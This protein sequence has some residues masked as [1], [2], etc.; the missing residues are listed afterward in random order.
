MPKSRKR[1]KHHQNHHHNRPLHLVRKAAATAAAATPGAALS[2]AANAGTAAATAPPVE[3]EAA[4]A[5]VAAAAVTS[6]AVRNDVHQPNRYTAASASA[7]APPSPS[8]AHS[9]PR[10]PASA[11]AAS[12]SSASGAS[13]SAASASPFPAFSAWQAFSMP[14]EPPEPVW[15]FRPTRAQLRLLRAMLSPD[16]DTVP[17]VTAVCE[18]IGI[19]RGTYYRWSED[20]AFMAWL[21]ANVVNHVSSFGPWALLALHH[22]AMNGDPHSSRHLN[23][24]LLPRRFGGLNTFLDQYTRQAAAAPNPL[25]P[26]EDERLCQLEWEAECAQRAAR[27]AATQQ[28]KTKAPKHSYAAQSAA[29]TT[30]TTQ[31]GPAAAMDS[32]LAEDAV[33]GAAANEVAGPEM[34]GREALN[35]PAAAPVG[36]PAAD[37]AAV[38]NAAVD[39]AADAAAANDPAAELA[40]E[41]AT[42]S[43]N[44]IAPG[45][46]AATGNP[47]AIGNPAGT[48][49]AATAERKP[50]SISSDGAAA[51]PA[52]RAAVAGPT[53]GAA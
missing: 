16:W 12:G 46:A 39:N 8:T 44:P 21:S 1:K 25:S 35:T 13:S 17:N 27:A 22:R 4:S 9:S 38:N 37:S 45:D 31:P 18:R 47:A 14:P 7:A 32:P 40:A 36:V 6:G 5:A 53:K 26:E 3:K 15:E 28:L 43:G 48:G 24:M 2:V 19:S 33:A 34:P 50:V 30:T 52:A 51:R 29:E 10:P 20:P 49:N 23:A 42:A 41:P 11:S